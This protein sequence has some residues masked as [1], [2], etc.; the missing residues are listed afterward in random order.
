M[1]TR[2]FGCMEEY[3]DIYGLCPHCGYEPQEIN[4]IHMHPGVVLH[5]RFLIG[6]VLGSGGFGVTYLA[7]DFVLQQKVAV[8]EY[9]PSEFATRMLGQTQVTAYGGKKEE[10]FCDGMVRFVEEAKRLAK[11]QSEDGIVRVY[12]SFTENNT[13]YIIMEF[14]DG[15]TLTSY[16]DRTGPVSIDDAVTMLTPVLRSLEVVHQE[17]IIHRDI[18]PDNIFL[19]K[20]GRVKL[21][22]FGA[23]RYATTSHSRSLTVIVK[24]GYS[25]E[26]QYRSRGNQGPHTDVYAMSAVLYRMVTGQVLPDAME[27][28]ALYE[29]RGKDVIVPPGKLT[30]L[31]RT[32]EKAILNGL[33]IRPEDRTAT[34]SQLLAELTSKT[35]IRRR[36]GAIKLP[37]PSHWPLW[38]KI[39][40][41]AAALLMTT[42]L[43]LA[44]TGVIGPVA[45][46]GGSI[47]LAEDEARVPNLVN[48][49][50]D[51]AHSKLAT[52]DLSYQIVGSE[53]S[54]VIPPN[55]V[56]HQSI[57]PGQ[58]VKKATVVEVYISTDQGAS[59][60]N[61]GAMPNLMYKTQQEALLLLEALQQEAQIEEVYS[62]IVAV[63]MVVDQDV[64]PG[65]EVAAGGKVILRVSKGPDPNKQAATEQL[66]TLSKTEY[67]L[68]VGDSVTILAQGGSGAYRYTSSDT[69]VVKV[70]GSGELTA[71]GGGSATITVSSDGAEDVT[72]TVVV[73]EYQ[74]YLSPGSLTLFA[75]GS[76]TI[77][78]YGIPS[79][80][81]VS[82]SSD[83][84]GVA[85]VNSSGRVTG[86]SAGTATITASWDSGVKTYYA[87]ASVTVQAE[88]LTLNTYKISSFYVGE[89]RSITA[90][91]SPSGGSVTWRSSNTS[92]ATVSGSGVVTAVGGGSCTITATFGS[93]TESCSVTVTQ[94]GISLTKG[95][96]YLYTGDSTGISASVTPG[97]ASVSWSS[98]DPGIASVSDGAIYAAG[99]GS[100]TIRASMT[101]AGVTYRASCTVS[102]TSPSVWVSQES[103]SLLPGGSATLTAGSDPSGSITWSSSNSGVATVSG[104]AVQA[105]SVGSA[106][107]TASM[108][109]AGKTYAASCYVT[110]SNPT[111]TVSSSADTI[112]FSG[113]SNGTCTLTAQVTPDGGSI[114]WSSSN[115]DVASISG[116]GITATLTARSEGNTTITATYSVS[117]TTVSDQYTITV[118][119]AQS[120]LSVNIRG[121]NGQSESSAI[122]L[123][124]FWLDG[125]VSSNYELTYADVIVYGYVGPFSGSAEF[126]YNVPIGSYE[127]E[128]GEEYLSYLMAE[129]KDAGLDLL[130]NIANLLWDTIRYEATAVVYDAS[131]NHVTSQTVVYYVLL[132]SY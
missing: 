18:A 27:R 48:H 86:V 113:I 24:P 6:R 79:Y 47:F 44:F 72:C 40:I 50:V 23:A 8:K 127:F 46:S 30:K 90:Y 17:G 67:D 78:V 26:E 126:R 131:G 28:R 29:R 83:S 73:R 122:L 111:I 123:S 87:Y 82:W 70:S 104:G 10:Q 91:T 37:T 71:L 31:T 96:V 33:N 112:E 21:I 7:W 84:R 61:P 38:A 128:M 32:Q 41:P 97:S 74:M 110:V 55:L 13:A 129:S 58:V 66:I 69:S 119:K 103:V 98:D 89:T 25:P 100:T 132:S 85:T 3:D 77:S 76:A 4:P 51:V 117:G 130:M 105:V 16:L 15:E 5:N 92:V 57:A 107:I 35:P 65:T 11:F 20:D 22:D 120:T 99:P 19:T 75:D 68:Y 49:S 60:Q 42:L 121:W 62:D 114:S 118:R 34:A 12:D 124:D 101:Y 93:H 88:G 43:V 1:R 108:T 53:F 115:P 63:G 102:V 109:Y 14:L 36:A 54:D 95:A 52:S 125:T 39:A 80:A 45:D 56:I 94:P 9:L 106:T 2:C 59:E 81:S 116:K 64:E